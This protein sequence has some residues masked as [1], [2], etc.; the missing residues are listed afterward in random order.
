MAT[1]TIRG[2]DDEV[3]EQLRVRAAE[4]GRSM[5]AE[6]RAILVDT[7][8]HPVPARGLGSRIHARFAAVDEGEFELPTRDEPPRVV[9][10]DA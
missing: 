1:L 9:D 3:R 5:E 6:V 7:L 10:F 2:L 4:H 8:S